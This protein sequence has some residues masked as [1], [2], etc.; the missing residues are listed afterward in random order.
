METQMQGRLAVF[1]SGGIRCRTPV[2]CTK[3]TSRVR[4]FPDNCLATTKETRA[5]NQTMHSTEPRIE[6]LSAITLATHDMARAVPFYEALSFSRAFGGP[7][8]AFTS[9]AFGTSYLNLISDARGPIHWW[10]RVIVYVSDV[11]AIY[12]KALAAGLRPEFPPSDAPWGE[13]YF[14][15]VDP[16]GHELSF[17]RPLAAPVDRDVP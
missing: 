4:H 16:D 8:E 11:D 6:S 3:Q 17:A 1:K 9:F 14:H 2:G 12:Q 15:I 5:M 7:D 10:G 13:R